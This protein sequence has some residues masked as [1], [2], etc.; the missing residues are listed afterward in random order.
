METGGA[1]F[2]S[3]IPVTS[4]GASVAQEVLSRYFRKDNKALSKKE[5]DKEWL[6]EK[7]FRLLQTAKQNANSSSLSL[8]KYLFCSLNQ[9]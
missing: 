5:L 1:P 8:F 9:P 3:S 2:Q 7:T 6:N 4:R